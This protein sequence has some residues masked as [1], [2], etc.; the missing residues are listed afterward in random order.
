M[1]AGGDVSRH[2]RP[3]LRLF[4]MRTRSLARVRVSSSGIILFTP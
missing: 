2:V 4:S 3:Y 1:K